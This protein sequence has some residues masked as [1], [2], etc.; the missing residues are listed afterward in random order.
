MQRA[1]RWTEAQPILRTPGHLQRNLLQSMWQTSNKS[2]ARKVHSQGFEARKPCCKRRSHSADLRWSFTHGYLRSKHFAGASQ[3]HWQRF[4]A[5]N[6]Y[7]T[8]SAGQNNAVGS[9]ARCVPEK[10]VCGRAVCDKKV[11]VTILWRQ[12]GGADGGGTARYRA[13]KQEPHTMMWGKTSLPVESAPASARRSA[14][15][16]W[17]E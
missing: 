11:C 10:V 5:R 15:V 9:N 17:Q 16:M 3:V 14:S 2:D 8:R 6:P 4:A 13:E 1:N 12:D 7:T